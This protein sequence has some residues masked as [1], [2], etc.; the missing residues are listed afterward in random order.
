[1]AL[2]MEKINNNEQDPRFFLPIA[3]VHPVSIVNNALWARI[4]NSEP[5]NS[6][7]PMSPP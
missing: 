6:A 4:K 3:N 5:Q 2:R 7:L 1:M